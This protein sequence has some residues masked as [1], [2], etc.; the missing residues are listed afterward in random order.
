MTLLDVALAAYLA[1]FGV[2]QGTALREVPAELRPVCGVLV[3][4]PAIAVGLGRYLR[5]GDADRTRNTLRFET[6]GQVLG[7][8]GL[9]LFWSVGAF[10]LSGL[11][12]LAGV[13]F[14]LVR[15]ASLMLGFVPPDEVEVGRWIGRREVWGL[16]AT[17]A[18]AYVI[19]S[20][21]LIL[22]AGGAALVLL[23]AWYGLACAGTGVAVG[24]LA[25]WYGV[26]RWAAYV[27]RS[28]VGPWLMPLRVVA[29]GTLG[30]GLVLSSWYVED[31][32]SWPLAAIGLF[33]IALGGWLAIAQQDR[34]DARPDGLWIISA[35]GAERFAWADVVRYHAIELN[36]S[37]GLQIV[38]KGRQGPRVFQIGSIRHRTPLADLIE[39]IERGF[40]RA[41][42]SGA[43]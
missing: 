29:F 34:W 37:P 35:S 31:S 4:M 27:P 20:N 22:L 28:R 12:L 11:A 24:L 17:A 18:S 26:E 41:A 30:C 3:V 40:A 8:W 9:L 25:S 14:T 36:N 7:L 33:S 21:T 2:L 42:L 38:V 10:R 13:S 1:V 23:G 5:N 39:G 15:S 32:L 6:A 43:S 16:A 19:G